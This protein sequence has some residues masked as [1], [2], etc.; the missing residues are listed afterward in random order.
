MSI[1]VRGALGF[2]VVSTLA[3]TS[4][5][6]QTS[7]SSPTLQVFAVIYSR[8]PA[9]TDDAKAFAHPAIKEHIGYF[10]SLGDRL[11]AASPFVPD[12]KDPTVGMVLMLAESAETAN[13]WADADPAIKAQ[14]MTNKAYRWRVS[15]IREFKAAR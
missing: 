2:L 14:V 10:T 3:A 4:P 13:A 12:A 9:W 7:P 5:A 11:I 1:L 6:A 15:S 8:G